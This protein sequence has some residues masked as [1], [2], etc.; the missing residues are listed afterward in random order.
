MVDFKIKS[1]LSEKTILQSKKAEIALRK[2]GENLL[3]EA[4]ANDSY[5]IF[6]DE[7]GMPRKAYAEE[8]KERLK[9]GIY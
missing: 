6:G 5:L 7:N 3:K 9:N 8:L 1:E 2:V 4:I